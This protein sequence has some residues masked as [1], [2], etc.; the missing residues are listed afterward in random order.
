MILLSPKMLWLQETG[1][2]LVSNTAFFD[3]VVDPLSQC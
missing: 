1:G 2:A 3:A